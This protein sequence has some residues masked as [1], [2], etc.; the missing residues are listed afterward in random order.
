MNKRYTV[1]YYDTSNSNQCTGNRTQ[2]KQD[3]L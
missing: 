1:G 3:M 2:I